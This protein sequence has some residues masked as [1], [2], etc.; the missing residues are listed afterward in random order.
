MEL[1]LILGKKFQSKYFFKM[2]GFRVKIFSRISRNFSREMSQFFS[3]LA[4]NSKREKCACLII[5]VSCLN[6]FNYL[7]IEGSNSFCNISYYIYFL[8]CLSTY[9]NFSSNNLEL[10]TDL[11]IYSLTQQTN[12]RIKY[13]YIIFHLV[14]IHSI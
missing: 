8:N 1:I 11:S 5:T 14:S 4:R 9:L 3:H 12:F 10:D 6:V 2:S 13:R 7:N